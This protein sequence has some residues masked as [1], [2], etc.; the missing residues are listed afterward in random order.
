MKSEYNKQ[1]IRLTMI[2]LSG[3][4]CLDQCFPKSGPRTIFDPQDFYFGPQGEK[5]LYNSNQK[6]CSKICIL[7][8]FFYK[9]VNYLTKFKIMVR[10]TVF[11]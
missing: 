4:Q 8:Q 7:Q 5:K 9:T 3:F 11:L 2:T 6:M 10:G 1:L